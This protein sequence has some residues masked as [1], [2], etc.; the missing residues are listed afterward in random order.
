MDKKEL[1]TEIFE[2]QSINKQDA[3]VFLNYRIGKALD[4]QQMLELL[5]N[6]VNKLKILA[7]DLKLELRIHEANPL[8]TLNSK[9]FY[10]TKEAAQVLEISPEKIRQL[11]ASGILTAKIINQRTW[12]VPSWSIEAYRNDLTRFLT[13]ISEPLESYDVVDITDIE[14]SLLESMISGEGIH[15]IFENVTRNQRKINNIILDL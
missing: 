13:N 15:K 11:V 7:D 8:V 14:N 2:K 9:Q 12:K 5:N 4:K 1:Y 3:L 6:S 10:S